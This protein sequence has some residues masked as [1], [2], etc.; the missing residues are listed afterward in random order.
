MHVCVCMMFYH[1]RTY[2]YT[3]EKGYA[4]MHV[5]AWCFTI[6]IHSLTPGRRD[7]HS[8]MCLHNVLPYTHIHLHQGERIYNTFMHECAYCFTIYTH[9][10]TPGRRAIH[11]CMCV[12][13]V[14]PYTHIHLHQGEGIYT[15]TCVCVCMMF[16]HIHTYTYTREKGY[17]FIR[18]CVW[19]FTIYT[20]TLT[21]G[22]GI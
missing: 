3:R 18:W 7:I 9:S 14:L 13:N 1:I 17:T 5:Y 21:P 8:C 20:H 11:W 12:N 15:H 16:Y 10:L 2:T 22:V 4:F 19:C 6:Y